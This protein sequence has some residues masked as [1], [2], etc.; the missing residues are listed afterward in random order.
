M[1]MIKLPGMNRELGAPKD[2]DAEKDGPCGSLPVF[3]EVSNGTMR[4]TSAW[5]PSAE[6]LDA[7]L[8]GG[9]VA[10]VIYGTLHPPIAVGT[11]A[12]QDV[13]GAFLPPG[14][15]MGAQGLAAEFVQAV[16]SDEQNGGYDISAGLFGP[17]L[18]A[19]IRRIAAV[20]L[21]APPEKAT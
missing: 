11:F 6:E 2:W 19:L 7:L 9:V 17:A 21:A 5:K 4:M 16:A 15:G 20:Y 1:E 13:P 10:L 3:A 12:P 18:S 8:R 14:V